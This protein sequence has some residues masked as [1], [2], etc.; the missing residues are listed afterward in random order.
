MPGTSDI[1]ELLDRA[2]TDELRTIRDEVEQ[3]LQYGNDVPDVERKPTRHEVV[4]YKRM[5]IFHWLQLNDLQKA[6]TIAQEFK[7]P[8][9]S[10]SHYLNHEMFER[11]PL[12]WCASSKLPLAQP[13]DE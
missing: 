10:I 8:M 11:R 6:V 3:R 13:R 2:S 9:A 7:I 1:L 4:A 12:G 5:Q